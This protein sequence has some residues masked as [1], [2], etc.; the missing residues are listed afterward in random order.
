MQ[1]VNRTKVLSGLIWRYA[2][3]CGAQGI[4]FVVS[5]VLARLLTPSDYGLIGLITVFISIAQVFAQSGLGQ[6]L[7]QRKDADSTDFSTVFYYSIVFSV[8]LYIILFLCSPLIADFYNAPELTAVIRVLSLTVIIGAVN[9]VQQAYVQKTMQFKRFFW[10]TLGGTLASAIVG[11][12]MAYKGFGV[13]ALVAQ[14]LT[15]QTIDTIVL[16]LTVKWR[17][18]WT[19][20]IER[21]KRLFSYGWKL[22]VTSLIY[23]VYN[24]IYSL[25]I[26]KVYSSTDLGYYNRGNQFPSVIEN[27]I[28]S[29]VEGVLFP[30]MSEVQD[31]KLRLK[32]VMQKFIISS[33]FLMFPVMAGLAA[34]AKPLVLILLTEKWLPA[35]PFIQFNCFVKAFM[36]I[37]NANLQTINATGRSD[38]FLKLEI[39][40]R[41]IGV[42]ILIATLPMGLYAM[43]Y[44]QCV[45]CMI[46]LFLDAFPNKRILGYSFLEQIK[47]IMPS[48]ILSFVMCIIVLC[49]NLLNLNTYITIIF[50]IMIGIVIYV[51]GALLFKFE[52]LSY[53]YNTVRDFIKKR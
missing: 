11:I 16:W 21:M 44:G 20:S 28:D 7:V 40:K 30:V 23:K 45:V 6:A 3:R 14:Q 17:P 13:W 37:F 33:T 26:G 12:I 49:V 4:Q 27:N 39:I 53:V 15:N 10:A 38:I 41:I 8:A 34:I 19:F 2:E 1:T 22:L 24:N 29:A 25:V 32:S 48:L 52:S 50:Q 9:S 43:M 18:T 31:D 46:E 51:G 42:L 47:D 5:I 36:P 35:V